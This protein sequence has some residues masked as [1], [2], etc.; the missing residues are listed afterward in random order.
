M[1]NTAGSWLG[2]SLEHQKKRIESEKV[3]IPPDKTIFY[4]AIVAAYLLIGFFVLPHIFFRGPMD[5]VWLIVL[6]TATLGICWKGAK[7]EN[8]DETGK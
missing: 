3:I 1:P 8:F 7:K 5:F 2:N 4:A 6:M